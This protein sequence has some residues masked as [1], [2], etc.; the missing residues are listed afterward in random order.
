MIYDQWWYGY[1]LIVLILIV[2]VPLLVRFSVSYWQYLEQQYQKY[3]ESPVQDN[4]L[5]RGSGG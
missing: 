4:D 2:Y 5:D 1:G 3:F